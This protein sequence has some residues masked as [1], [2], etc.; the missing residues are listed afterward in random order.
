M[1]YAVKENRYDCCPVGASA[2]KSIEVL[3]SLK[4]TFPEKNGV[5][6][7]WKFKNAHSI[8]HFGCSENFSTEGP[9]H[10]HIDFVK[11]IAHGTNNKEIF[12][13]FL[14]AFRHYV[15]EGHL[16]FL[17]QLLADLYAE[18]HDEIDKAFNSHDRIEAES[19]ANDSLPCELGVLYPLLQSIMAGRRNHQTLQVK[20]YRIRYC[21]RYY[22]NQ[23][24]I[25]LF[26][27]CRLSADWIESVKTRTLTFTF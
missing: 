8:L 11:K 26:L 25:S 18:S 13:L 16:Q 22:F 14:T 15:R 23:L 24:M 12:Q 9:E 5:A 27:S 10:C 17:N 19:A 21:I 4:S 1:A 6:N 2:T 20:T 3:E 7:G